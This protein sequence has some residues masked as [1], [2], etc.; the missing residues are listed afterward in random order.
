M[1]GVLSFIFEKFVR[2]HRKLKIGKLVCIFA[3]FPYRIHFCGAVFGQM[4]HFFYFCTFFLRLASLSGVYISFI[5]APLKRTWG[6][7]DS[8]IAVHS[9]AS[10][11]MWVS[12]TLGLQ[13]I[14]QTS[15]NKQECRMINAYQFFNKP[16]WKFVNNSVHGTSNAETR[17]QKAMLEHTTRA[18]AYN[19]K[20][21]S[22]AIRHR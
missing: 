8:G 19:N 21:Y 2:Q 17:G 16:V 18:R 20:Q 10:I 14:A 4:S 7:L 12:W 11:Q 5:L 9:Y 1:L 15:T 6:T 13:S 22:T 3:I